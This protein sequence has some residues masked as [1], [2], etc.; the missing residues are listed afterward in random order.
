MR[1]KQWLGIVAALVL[2]APAGAAT[3]D[4]VQQSQSI[5]EGSNG[6]GGSITGRTSL[7]WDGRQQDLNLAAGAFQLQM[8]ETGTNDAYTD[9]MAF[10]VEVSSSIRTSTGSAISYTDTPDLFDPIRQTLVATLFQHVYDPTGSV[11]HQGAFQLALWKLT[12]GDLVQTL[13]GAF[14]IRGTTGLTPGVMSFV[15]N[16]D[17]SANTRGF[18]YYSPGVLDL[19]QGWLDNLDGLG[20]DWILT[21]LVSDHVTFLTNSNSQNIVTAARSIPAVPLPPAVLLSG[22]GLLAL[23]M[24]R[25]RRRES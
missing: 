16:A 17:G 3:Y 2:A 22:A 11:L 9:F 4:V 24:L 23:V 7:W 19:A 14:D 13:G 15:T 10:C 20:T 18:D 21:G 5:F 6:D 1:W 25:R 12:S 8:R